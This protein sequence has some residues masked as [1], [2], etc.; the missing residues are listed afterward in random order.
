MVEQFYA[1]RLPLLCAGWESPT[2]AAPCK[3]SNWP[4][5]ETNMGPHLAFRCKTFQF[6]P[7]RKKEGKKLKDGRNPKIKPNMICLMSRSYI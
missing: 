3:T 2:F 1:A 5:I 6:V 7:K 4:P